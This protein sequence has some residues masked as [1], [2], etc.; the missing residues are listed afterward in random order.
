MNS[1]LRTATVFLFPDGR[2][3]VKN[4]AAY[5]GVAVQTLAMWRCQGKG[6]RYTKRGRVFYFKDDLDDWVNAGRSQSTAQRQG[7]AA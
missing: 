1:S 6:P 7:Q 4:A 2:M 3:D 5:V